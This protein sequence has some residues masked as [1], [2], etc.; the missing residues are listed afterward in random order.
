MLDDLDFVRAQWVKSL[1]GDFPREFGTGF[2]YDEDG[3]EKQRVVRG[4]LYGSD[5]KA[6]DEDTFVKLARMH[7]GVQ[8]S[9][10]YA[11]V[12]SER[13][14]KSNRCD[15]LFLDFDYNVKGAKM[16]LKEVWR[17]VKSVHKYLLDEYKCDADVRF[18]GAKGFHIYI[19]FPE[20]QFNSPD[21]V[22]R[23]FRNEL[24]S[25]LSLKSLDLIGET[26]R[27]SRLVYTWNRKLNSS[28][29]CIPVSVEWKL[30]KILEQ[31]ERN[32]EK[33]EVNVKKSMKIMKRLKRIDRKYTK[34]KPQKVVFDNTSFNGTVRPCFEDEYIK[35]KF[36]E[37]SKNH[38]WWLGITWELGETDLTMDE[39]FKKMAVFAGKGFDSQKTK[40]Q[41][42]FYEKKKQDGNAYHASCMKLFEWEWCMKEVCPLFQKNVLDKLADRVVDL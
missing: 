21:E 33:L 39:I 19:H 16:S 28:R 15:I 4:A 31:S 36:D 10:I 1:H 24:R 29:M 35:K 32:T 40:E 34:I 18:S 22:K 41:L 9:N 5:V 11:G 42:A 8:N 23:V 3:K 38:F 30:S 13:Q 17:E 14:K 20:R 37:N 7:F 12:N 26:S 2:A 25:K 27:I 6:Y